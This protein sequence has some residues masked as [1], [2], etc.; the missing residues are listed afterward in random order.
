MAERGIPHDANSHAAYLGSSLEALR[1]DFHVPSSEQI[2]PS[3]ESWCCRTSV[4]RVGNFQP[5][6]WGPYDRG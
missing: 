1:D 2:A 3:S 6:I 5:P 4:N